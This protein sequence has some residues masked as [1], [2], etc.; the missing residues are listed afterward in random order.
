[1]LD[2]ERIALIIERFAHQIYEKH[3]KAKDLVI[4]GI[5]RRGYEVASRIKK[6]LNKISSQSIALESITLDKVNPLKGDIELS[7]ES[8]NLEAKTIV[9]VDDVLNSGKTLIYAVQFVLNAKV[10]SISTVVLVDRIHRD[11]PIKAD[12]VGMTLSTT[13]QE[14]VEVELGKKDY[15]YLV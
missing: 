1:M 11:F 5:E 9:L 2:H 7:T 12:I 8:K 10:K 6:H 15:A 13:L 14:R 4:I 3:H